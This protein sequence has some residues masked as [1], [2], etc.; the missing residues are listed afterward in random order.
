MTT[1]MSEARED[2]EQFKFGVSGASGL[3]G[4]NA[5]LM[6]SGGNYYSTSN[7]FPVDT[8]ITISG[9][10]IVDNVVIK[11]GT[12][13]QLDNVSNSYITS[14]TINSCFIESGTVTFSNTTIDVGTV[15][16]VSDCT[17][18]AMPQ[19]HV[20]I[21]TPL[22]LT[23]MD[24]TNTAS[25]VG[26]KG[27][28]AFDNVNNVF[29]NRMYGYDTDTS[30]VQPFNVASIV[31]NSPATWN[32]MCFPVAGMS[33]ANN[34]WYPLYFDESSVGLLSTLIDS[35][36]KKLTFH[37][38]DDG[39][40]TFAWTENGVGVYTVTDG[41]LIA[42]LYSD[43]NTLALYVQ[44]VDTTGTKQK[45]GTEGAALIIDFGHQEIHDG[46][47]YTGYYT[48]TTASTDGH[49]SA[50]YIKTPSSGQIHM[51]IEFS[52]STAATFSIDEAP[53]IDADTGTHT[54]TCFN[55]YRDS[56]NTSTILDND[57]PAVA[58]YYTTYNETQL[59]AANYTPGTI[60]RTEPLQAGSGPK[61]AGGTGRDT[62]EYIL[63]AD[64]IY[65][66]LITNT[67][68]DANKHHI[69]IDWYEL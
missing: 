30:L 38:M 20:D 41:D 48:R 21:V 54:N 22:G 1:W 59:A 23:A 32:E 42:P 55:R 27:S 49:R 36:S 50:I 58:G 3:V 25:L 12:L 5:R 2:N 16:T 67:S 10:I 7:R 53:T 13:N 33:D 4:L 44:P 66:F 26:I 37:T 15:S 51:V 40:D 63:A 9:G 29:Q 45:F 14:G 47:S 69:M 52:S 57:S 6:D 56:V 24:E 39:G 18:T 28:V 17:V 31:G 64:T 46:D 68:A 11:S 35:T 60:L 8:E 19:T 65:L 34:Y 43:D 61:P 62:Q